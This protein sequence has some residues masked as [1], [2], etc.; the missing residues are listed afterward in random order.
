MKLMIIRIVLVVAILGMGG[1]AMK[2]LMS[3]KKAP[4]KK[5]TAP[6]AL[7]VEVVKA[8]EKEA[9]VTLV[10]LGSARAPDV[11]SVVPEVGGKVV[12]VSERLE[13]GRL[14][15]AGE[16]LF[17]IDPELFDL[18]VKRAEREQERVKLSL[19]VLR[20]SKEQDTGRLALARKSEAL[21]RK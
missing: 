20:Q 1:G 5:D 15:P 6:P 4:E 16:V 18:A 17:R 13:A 3:Q 2:G 19:E 21:A 7:P 14:V 12:E 9:S 11:L 10:G 8:V